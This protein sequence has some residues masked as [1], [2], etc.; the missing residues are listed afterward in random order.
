MSRF[1][2][3]RRVD[4]PIAARFQTDGKLAGLHTRFVA[5]QPVF[6]PDEKVFRYELLFRDGI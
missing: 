1:A 5:R 6:T 4:T 2:D 3:R